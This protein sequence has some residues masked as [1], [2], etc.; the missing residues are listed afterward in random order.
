MNDE[1]E[2]R[3][4]AIRRLKAKKGFQANLVTYVVINAF[5]I[6]IWA[7]TAKEKTVQSF[8]P[9]WVIMGWGI[10]LA[11]HAWSVYGVKPITEDEIQREMGRG[12][13]VA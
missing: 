5:L 9:I 4:A 2:A 12:D 1:N 10:G 11:M 13:G 6:G 7:M 3:K 8:W